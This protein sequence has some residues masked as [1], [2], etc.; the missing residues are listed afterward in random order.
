MN[1][2][3]LYSL[4]NAKSEAELSH[5]AD[6]LARQLGFANY[7]YGVQVTTPAAKPARYINSNYP[8][9]WMERYAQ[10]NYA[11]IDPVLQHCLNTTLPAVWQEAT[12]SE[13]APQMWEEAASY[14]IKYGISVPIHDPSGL[15]GIFSLARDRSLP[16]KEVPA[17]MGEAQLLS[18]FLHVGMTRVVIPTAIPES[19]IDLTERERECL[20]W[21]AAGKTAWEIGQILGIAER[22]A[23]FH[24]NN[25]VQKLGAQN[26]TQAVAKAALLGLLNL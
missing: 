20:Q 2:D 3:E 1:I 12:F 6:K 13:A 25:C 18:N 11:A 22:T 17:I 23:V 7:L 26:K 16:L 14:G 24:L 8:Y 5:T 19:R 10:E 21:A 15:N 4:L 9:A